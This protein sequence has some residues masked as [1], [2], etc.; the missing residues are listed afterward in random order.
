MKYHLG[1]RSPCCQLGTLKKE[2]SG[3]DLLVSSEGKVESGLPEKFV[4]GCTYCKVRYNAE[5][6]E[7][8]YLT[9]RVKSEI[10]NGR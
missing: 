7:G 2:S 1:H 6:I 3:F 8:R 4:M 10:D 9:I 5:K